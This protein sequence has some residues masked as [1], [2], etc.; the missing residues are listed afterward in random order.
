MTEYI[1]SES[2][3]RY[4]L[5]RKPGGGC[6]SDGD[7]LGRGDGNTIYA[8]QSSQERAY[9]K[10][11]E[12]YLFEWRRTVV[13]LEALKGK[14]RDIMTPKGRVRRKALLALLEQISSSRPPDILL[15][16]E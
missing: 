8:F 15:T 12:Q 7:D 5:H 13:E 3:G 2:D 10:R 14:M 11:S 6:Y 16:P 4:L 1:E 9:F